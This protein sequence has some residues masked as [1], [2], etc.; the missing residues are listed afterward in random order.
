MDKK[1]VGNEVNKFV[2][3]IRVTESKKVAPKKP[4]KVK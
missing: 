2:G 1:T 3:S 4:K